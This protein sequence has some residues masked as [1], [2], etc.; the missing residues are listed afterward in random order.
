[1]N[2]PSVSFAAFKQNHRL[3]TGKYNYL[4]LKQT[5]CDLVSFGNNI[6]LCIKEAREKLNRI[7]SELGFKEEC[8][9]A[10]PPKSTSFSDEF[11]EIPKELLDL[12]MS[13]FEKKK[14]EPT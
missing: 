14:L 6:G 1:M 10:E 5:N 4:K 7:Y 13:K 8:K 9:H 11:S 12:F 2:L 3:N